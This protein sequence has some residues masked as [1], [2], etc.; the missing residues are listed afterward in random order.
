[1][2]TTQPPKPLTAHEIGAY[3]FRVEKFGTEYDREM[4]WRLKATIEQQRQQIEN[5][6]YERAG[7][8]LDRAAKDSDHSK[9]ARAAFTIAA[10]F[11][12]ELIQ[13]PARDAEKEPQR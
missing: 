7:E 4:V 2:T 10:R 12:R 13:P 5:A 8:K 11:V 6:A 3:L 9:V 1:M